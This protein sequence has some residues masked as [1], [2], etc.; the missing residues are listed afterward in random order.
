MLGVN[1]YSSVVDNDPV[2][3][4]IIGPPGSES[5]NCGLRILILILI[6]NLSFEEIYDKSS[7]FFYLCD[8]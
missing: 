4:V 8:P 5:L 7:I 2:D 1:D 6:F 3:P